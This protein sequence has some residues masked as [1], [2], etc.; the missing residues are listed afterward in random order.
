MA[1]SE[2]KYFIYETSTSCSHTSSF[3]TDKCDAKTSNVNENSYFS[4][5]QKF[6]HSAS[7]DIQHVDQESPKSEEFEGTNDKEEE[8]DGDHSI[9]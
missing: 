3:R 9:Q 2:K 1:S 6:D 7:N 4:P 5:S 8:Y